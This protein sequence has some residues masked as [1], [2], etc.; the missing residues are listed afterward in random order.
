[1]N[2][3]KK[4]AVLTLCLVIP[5]CGVM[6]GCGGDDTGK[7]VA[8][9]EKTLTDGLTDTYT[10]TYTDGTSTTFQVTN[11]KDGSDGED[12]K[13]EDIFAKYLESHPTATYEQFLKDFLQVNANLTAISTNKALLS[14]AKIYTEFTAYKTVVSGYYYKTVIDTSVSCGSA[15]IY[16]IESDYTYFI[17]NYHVVYNSSSAIE[18]KLPKR[19][20]LYLYGS[21]GVPKEASEKGSDGY[22][23]YDYGDYGLEAEYVGGSIACDIAIVRVQTQKV[24]D[25][26]PNVREVVF[27]DEYRVGEKAIAIG[28]PEN[29]G[30]SVTEGV[31]SVDNEYIS[32]NIDGTARAYRS[33]RIDTAIYGGSSGGGLFNAD[34]EL[35]G[36]TNAGDGDDQNVNY[37]VPLHIVKGAAESIMYY[38]KNTS[39]TSCKKLVMGITVSTSNAK[40]QLDEET[41]YGKISETVKIA[42]VEENSVAKTLGLEVGNV[43]VSIKLNG[44]EYEINR[45]FDIGDLFLNVRAGDKLSVKYT[46]GGAEK[47]TAEITVSNDDLVAVG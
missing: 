47:N 20:N 9:I 13:I 14:S 2:F 46:N 45:D 25:V 22:T 31:V 38:C 23:A 44:V 1:M 4:L 40:Y 33:I 19:I 17:T 36:I 21:E 42:S 18:S 28:N 35:I 6:G 37:A 41:G 7:S 39:E 16:K 5:V 10:I 11:G 30:L 12:L 15:V 34:G 43:I 3:L 27:A 26:N 29:E 8:S 32:L 24:K